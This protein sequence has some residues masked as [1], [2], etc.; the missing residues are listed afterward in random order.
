[1]NFSDENLE[2]AYDKDLVYHESF[3]PNNFGTSEDAVEYVHAYEPI[4]TLLKELK[5]V[6]VVCKPEK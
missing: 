4:L 5:E 2:R 3:E 1:M 6:C